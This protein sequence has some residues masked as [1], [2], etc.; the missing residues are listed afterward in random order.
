MAAQDRFSRQFVTPEH[1][2]QIGH[3]ALQGPNGW[4]LFVACNAG[5]DF[6]ETVR[7]E[8]EKMLRENGSSVDRIPMIGSRESPITTVFADTETC[9]R[10][11]TYAAGSNAYVFQSCHQPAG[12]NTVNENIQQ[13]IQVVRTLRAHRAKTITVVT[14]Y[15]PYSR[16]D[17]P[18]FMRREAVLARLFADQLKIAGADIHL[19]YHPHTYSLH[20]FYEPEM[21]FVALSGLA[22]LAE[23]FEEMMGQKDTV[24]VSTDAGGAKFTMH[25]ADIMDINYAIAN[26]F[27][28]GKDK[29]DI[30]GV[31][32]DL[33]GKKTAIITDDETVTGT[34]LLNAV[35][36]LHETYGIPEV[37][38]AVSHMKM[39]EEFVPQLVEAHRSWG[40]KS[41]HITDT[42]PLV[43]A[44]RT[45]NF[46]H[47]HPIARRFAATINHMHYDQSVSTLFRDH[48]KF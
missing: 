27:R 26:K 45:L 44:V 41:M 34:S 17:K 46:V 42:V 16:Q 37:R 20:G 47:V 10:L 39:P 18:T 8:Y 19:C 48:E 4:L 3:R 31:I 25:Y 15:C 43:D 9:P 6:A 2:E 5:I 35:R 28:T 36:Q 38:V 13:L 24:V 21:I 32:G 33:E 30:L 7:D 23:I 22:L 14:P 29:A 40:L 11:G 12:G 1:F